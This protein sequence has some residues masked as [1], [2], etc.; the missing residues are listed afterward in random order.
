MQA[1]E[2]VTMTLENK[3]AAAHAFDIDEFDVHIPIPAQEELTF[4][5]TPT[6]PGTYTF[7]CGVL[8]H[9]GG[10]MVGTLI[11]E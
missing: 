11:V 7:Y 1:G 6:Q 4:T 8:G 3:D 2:L 5:F 9:R 10:G